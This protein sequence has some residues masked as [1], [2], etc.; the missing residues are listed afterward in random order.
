MR[1]L[2]R[3]AGLFALVVGLGGSISA[4]EKKPLTMGQTVS[5]TATVEGVDLGHRIVTLKG[6]DGNFVAVEVPESVKRLSDVK[7]GDRL[8]IKYS[9]SLVLAVKKADAAAKLGTST[10]T[11]ITR[12]KG[13]KPSAVVSETVT[14]TV[15]IEAIDA[16]LPS[17]TVRK[18]DGSTQ[19]FRVQDPKNLEGVKVG[20]HIVV[21][22]REA[23]ALQ[24]S[25]P[26]A[27]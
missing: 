10:D 22:Y 23:V 20:D 1:S 12:G 18:A 15:A 9:E 3:L 19:S 7:V 17:I 13:E 2:L 21:T 25:A 4:Q 11:G 26:P 14:A 16:K 27:K 5:V 6:P 24:V 8:T